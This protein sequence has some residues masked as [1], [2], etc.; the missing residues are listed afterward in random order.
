MVLKNVTSSM[1]IP[2]IC[3]ILKLDNGKMVSIA[4]GQ[5]HRQTET[6]TD[7]ITEASSTVLVYRFKKL[8][9]YCPTRWIYK[10]FFIL[11]FIFFLF[12]F[13]HTFIY[14]SF[15]FC[16][17]FQSTFFSI[18]SSTFIFTLYSVGPVPINDIQIHPPIKWPNWVFVPKS[19]VMF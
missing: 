18:P 16:S 4:K 6:Q 2:N 10:V 7:R 12:I 15:D 5:N 11:S 9:P 14:I 13:L 3:L 19:G 8:W 1:R 17:Q